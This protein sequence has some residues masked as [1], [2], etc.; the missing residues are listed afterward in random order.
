MAADISTLTPLPD[1]TFIDD[2]GN[3][4]DNFG[5]PIT[6]PSLTT[7]S[8]NPAIGNTNQPSNVPAITGT[9]ANFGTSMAALLMGRSVQTAAVKVGPAPVKIGTAAQMSA[10]TLLL[11]VLG[12]IILFRVLK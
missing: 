5:N 7:A 10:G 12:G 3:F 2:A 11:L 9:L 6:D 1:G 4:Y 8:P